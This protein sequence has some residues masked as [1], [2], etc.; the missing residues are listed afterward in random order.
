[1]KVCF[2]WC[3]TL[4]SLIGRAGGIVPRI[5]GNFTG[6]IGGPASFDGVGICVAPGVGRHPLTLS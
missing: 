3:P 4:A 1:M 6:S 5:T 2:G